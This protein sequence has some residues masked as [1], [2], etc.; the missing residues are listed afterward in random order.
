MVE[1]GIVEIIEMGGALGIIGTMFIVL[2]F[3]RKQMQSLSADIQTKVLNDLDEKVRKMAEIIIEK[4][5]MQ[6]V[7]YKL[8]KPSEELAFAYYILFICS[9]AYAMRQ[10]K[11]INDDDWTG[12][13]HWMKNCFKYGTIGEQWKLTQSES[14][15]DPSFQV[16]VNKELVPGAHKNSTR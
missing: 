16:F 3:S 6:K 1:I 15:F 10:R 11:V 2:Y 13:L 7:I 12:W 14:W 9:H 8:E 4:P 5:S